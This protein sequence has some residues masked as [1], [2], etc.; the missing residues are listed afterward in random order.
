VE[1]VRR[2]VFFAMERGVTAGYPVMDVLAVLVGGSYSPSSSSEIGYTSAASHAFDNA[3]SK[4]GGI[5]LEPFM[6]IEVTTPKDFVGDIIG[7]LNARG[8]RIIK[9]S[10]RQTA[11]RID[12]TIPLSK[13]F[14]YTTDL[15]SMSQGR[16]SYTME[17][18][19]FAPKPA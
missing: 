13:M 4:A 17:F 15:R 10:S 2:G 7:D 1:S 9:I 16:A 6:S 3:C 5:L 12:A 8:G 19:H 18:S 14:G 11:E